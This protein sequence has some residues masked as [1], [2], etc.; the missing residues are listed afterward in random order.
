MFS[1]FP[2][3]GVATGADKRETRRSCPF[4]VVL[5]SVCAVGPLLLTALRSTLAFFGF[6]LALVSGEPES[7]EILICLEWMELYR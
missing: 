6:P 1:R 5:W 3:W 2:D 7:R 4:P